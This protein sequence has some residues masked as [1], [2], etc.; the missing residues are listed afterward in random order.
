MRIPMRTTILAAAGLVL[1]TA[2]A[3]RGYPISPVTLWSLVERSETIVYAEVFKVENHTCR[4]GEGI[5]CKFSSTIATLHVL[6]TWKGPAAGEIQVPFPA[7]L[8]CP[9]PPRY[10]KGAEV[11]AFLSRDKNRWMTVGLSYG[12]LYPDGSHE[13]E[14]LRA[15]TARA[16]SL[17]ETKHV[18]KEDRVDWI[19]EAAARP[20]TRWHGLY[21]L[22]PAGD[23]VHFFYDRTG[24]RQ[25]FALSPAQKERIARGFIANP[26][27]DPTL[28]MTLRVLAGYRSAQVDRTTAAAIEGL[29]GETHLSYW[30]PAS[31][32]LALERFGDGQA[33]QKV[34]AI[35][36]GCCEFDEAGA[37]NLWRT[38]Q[39]KLRIP[40]VAPLR[41]PVRRGVRGVGGNT[42]S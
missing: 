26:P 10:V 3:A 18:S 25:S 8:I 7:G 33:A 19:V 29:L 20:G 14:D 32:E 37:R 35:R 5:E 21:E 11:V 13:L 24:N 34:N 6:E 15:M 27:L 28:T 36:K 1:V 41:P 30:L 40:S 4:S 23:E 16:V 22:E 39:Q 38:A 31:M 12:T 2:S 17:Q 9:A 42:P